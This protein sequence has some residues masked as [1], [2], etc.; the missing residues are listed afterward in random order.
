MSI[1]FKKYVDIVSG[2]GGGVGIRLRDLIGRL[3]TVNPLLPPRSLVE[4]T[5][6]EDVGT[7]FGTASEE[8]KRA[9]FYF[10]FV[11]KTITKANKISFARWAQAAVTPRVYG[12]TT[13]KLL[14]TYTA[15]ANGSLNLTMGASTE[16]TTPID[17]TGAASLAAVAALIQTA[18]RL[19]AG[20]Q[21]AA[22]TVVY[23]APTQRFNL[24]GGVAE[25]AAM[26]VN[27]SGVGTDLAPLLGWTAG[28][29]LVVAEGSDAETI[30][31]TLDAS[32][33]ASN[34]FGSLLFLPALDVAEKEE[35]AAWV[36]LQNNMYINC[37]RSVDIAE[38]TADSVAL[39][40]YGGTAITLAT[41]AD[42]YDEMA[43]MILLAATDYARRNSSQNYMFQ[44]FTLTPKVTTTVDSNG[45]DVLRVNYYGQT[46]TAGQ[47][48]SFYQ[49]GTLCG[50]PVDATDMNVY[51]NEIW[52]KD[53][54][55][56]AI[57]ALLLALNRVPANAQGRSQLLTTLQ[58]VITKA[59]FNGVISVGKELDNTQKLYIAQLTGDPLAFHQVQNAGYWLDCV[60]VPYVTQSGATEFK[61][62]YTLIYSKDDA[63]RKV[64]GSHV[65]I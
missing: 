3:F 8:Y 36:K 16:S 31:E 47:A 32:A 39:L 43:P 40:G 48:I 54:A 57:M 38:A 50:L 6:P 11:S 20:A 18:I 30:T 14:A 5:T 65:L 44:I 58:S 37:N 62:V 21:F 25:Q 19:E 60:M 7:Y 28:A 49:R 9:S 22:A 15:V 29:G 51:A 23:D 12:N 59:L 24:A 34:N 27:V 52:F 42:E 64:E 13:A 56:A 10:A 61:A 55:G 2:V 33:D 1:S 53:A 45:L 35:V 46:Q 26:T 17:L 4:F 41:L 63:I